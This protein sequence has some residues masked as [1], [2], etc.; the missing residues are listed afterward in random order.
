MERLLAKVT[1]GTAGPRDVLALGRS[2][3]ALPA[4]QKQASTCRSARLAAIATRIDELPDV[5]DRILNGLTD[6]P[7][8]NIADGG[9]IRDG[10]HR[11]LDE[12]RDISRNS[13]HTSRRSSSGNAPAR[14]FNR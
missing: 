9:A 14:P 10:A 5:R 7:P 4:I 8:V 3:A 12:L 11:E 2:I 6:S 1:L 13:K